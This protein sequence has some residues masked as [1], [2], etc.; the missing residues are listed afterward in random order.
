[1]SIPATLLILF[2]MLTLVG[3]WLRLLAYL[4]ESNRR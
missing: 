4:V 1:M 3:G 2:L